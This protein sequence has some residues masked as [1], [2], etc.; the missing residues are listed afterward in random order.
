M[1]DEEAASNELL[2]DELSRLVAAYEAGERQNR[3]EAWNLIA[4]LAVCNSEEICAALK[5][6]NK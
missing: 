3:Q 6:A 1:S 4:D 5:A 2:S